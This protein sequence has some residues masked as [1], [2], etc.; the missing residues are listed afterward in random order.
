MSFADISLLIIAGGHSSRM[1]Q[2]KRLIEIN[3]VSLLENILI[4]ASR[5]N[6]VNTF[7]CVEKRSH[8]IDYLAKKYNANVLV[9]KVQ[10][11]GPMSGILEGLVNMDTQWALAVS[12][13]M[14]F[15]NFEVVTPL[16]KYLKDYKVVMPSHQPL[17][18]FYHKSLIEIF[19]KSLENNQRKLHFAIEKV[20]HKLVEINSTAGFFNVNTPADLRLAQGRAINMN[21]RV[22]II[23]IIAPASGTGKTTFIENLIIRLKAMNIKVGV[24]KSDAHGFNLDVEGK[25]SWRFQ[26]AGAQSIAV[27]SPKG[28]FMIQNSSSREDLMKIANKMEGVDLILTESRTHGTNPAISLYRSIREPIISDDVVAIFTDKKIDD[29]DGILQFNL[30]DVEQALKTCIF[31]MGRDMDFNYE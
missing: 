7:L 29:V 12:C 2:D 23:S 5:E 19:K 1:K 24:V 31:L 3:G 6:F 28:W 11:V 18:A 4:K 21:R 13:D 10:N 30:N 20:H 9:D 15:F 22:P 16:I 26:Q 8:F 14:P 17:I 25:D 27:V